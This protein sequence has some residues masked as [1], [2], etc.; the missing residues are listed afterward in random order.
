MRNLGSRDPQTH[1]PDFVIA[2][3]KEVDGLMAKKIWKKVNIELI[4]LDSNIIGERFMMT[5]K[6]F[7]DAKR[8]S[9]GVV[10]STRLRRLGK[11]FHVT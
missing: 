9:E 1:E 10:Y 3:K 8:D 11:T 7:P 4:P 6:N 5:L 2:K